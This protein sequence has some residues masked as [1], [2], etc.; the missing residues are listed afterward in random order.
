MN[1]SLKYTRTLYGK[2]SMLESIHPVNSPTHHL[3]VGTDRH[4]FFTLSWDASQKQLRTEKEYVDLSDK[5][6]RDSQ[7]MDKA[8]IDP[9][10]NFLTLELFEGTLTLIPLTQRTKKNVI[11]ARETLGEP[12]QVRIPEMFVRS[13]AYLHSPTPGAKGDKPR[14]V[15]LYEDNQQ[16]VKLQVKSLDFTRGTSG[17]VG[18]DLDDE[19]GYRDDIDNSASHVMPVPGPYCKLLGSIPIISTDIA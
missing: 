10:R 14:L 18:V 9:Q 2:I 15:L 4:Q 1:L 11:T 19:D 13:S 6:G 8:M 7:T 17:E 5:T 12:V 3:F 16:S